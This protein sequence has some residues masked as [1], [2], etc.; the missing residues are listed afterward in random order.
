MTLTE[1]ARSNILP[2]AS[3]FFILCKPLFGRYVQS[4]PYSW[5]DMSTFLLEPEKLTHKF[6]WADDEVTEINPDSIGNIRINL[7]GEIGS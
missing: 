6:P 4:A 1:L 3:V 7:K 5:N 2:K